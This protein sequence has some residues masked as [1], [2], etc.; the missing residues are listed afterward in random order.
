MCRRNLALTSKDVYLKGS[1][2]KTVAKV[3]EMIQLAHFCHL[4]V[5]LKC[6][7]QEEYDAA[8]T[9]IIQHSENFG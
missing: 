2:L 4:N 9:D 8:M 3:F 6:T 5:S 1:A 7:T